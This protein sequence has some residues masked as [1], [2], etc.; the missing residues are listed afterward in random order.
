MGMA[1]QCTAPNAPAL[2]FGYVVVYADGKQ[3]RPD[4]SLAKASTGLC[5]YDAQSCVHLQLRGFVSDMN[6]AGCIGA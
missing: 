2:L 4:A 3:E 6:G 5:V 1:L